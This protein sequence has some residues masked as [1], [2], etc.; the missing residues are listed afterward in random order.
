[1]KKLLILAALVAA[2]TACQPQASSVSADVAVAKSP[3]PV[4]A[5]AVAAPA[6]LEKAASPVP[7]FLAQHNMARLLQTATTGEVAAEPHVYNGFYGPDHRRIELAFTQVSRAKSRPNVYAIQG[8][9]R[10]KSVI[11]PFAGTLVLTRVIGQPHFSKKE[12]AGTDDPLGYIDPALDK[13]PFYTVVGS[14]ILRED[15]THKNAGVF[16]GS[17]ALDVRPD[18]AS[19]LRLE[20]RTGR[21]LTRG[22]QAKFTGTWTPYGPGSAKPVVWVD[23]I[24]VYGAH[25]FSHFTL[26]DRDIDFNPKYA[27]LGWNTYWTNDEWWADGYRATAHAALRRHLLFTPPVISPKDLAPAN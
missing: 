25:V 26:G 7:Q 21:T 22:G 19:G 3:A 17:A 8:K 15:S 2:G 24:F 20:S 6:P 14:F 18:P 11:T 23:N 16:Q 10:Y 1:M 13:E 27:K 4:A 5:P 12:L 9:S